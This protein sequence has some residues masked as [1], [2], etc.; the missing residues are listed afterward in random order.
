M[1]AIGLDVQYAFA[2]LWKVLLAG[3]VLGAGLPAAFAGGVRGVAVFVGAGDRGAIGIPRDRR[4][5]EAL[6]GAVVM[7][8]LVAYAVVAAL[9]FIVAS[10]RGLQLT[11]T[12]VVPWLEAR[13]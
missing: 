1:N 8:L 6:L 7:F 10:G 5:W 13:S 3:L 9:L 12:H 11:F 2:A 4:R